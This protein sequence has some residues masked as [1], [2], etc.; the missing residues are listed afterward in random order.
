M[1]K[2]IGKLNLIK[3]KIKI[4]IYKD[5]IKIILKILGISQ[6]VQAPY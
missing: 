4:N 5:N 2:N 3:V 6:V 1:P